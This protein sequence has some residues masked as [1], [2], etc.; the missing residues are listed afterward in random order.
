MIHKQNNN[1]LSKN[2]IDSVI[3]TDDQLKKQKYIDKNTIT[4]IN[5]KSGLQRFIQRQRKTA[6]MQL[7]LICQKN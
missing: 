1:Q 7:G 5:V 4:D 3:Y 6:K 2:Y